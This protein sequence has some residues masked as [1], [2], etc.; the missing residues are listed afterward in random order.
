VEEEE[1]D[2]DEIVKKKQRHRRVEEEES[3]EG[4][5]EG[6]SSEGEEEE[7]EEEEEGDFSLYRQ[8]ENWNDEINEDTPI[9]R[10]VTHLLFSA[11]LSLAL[12]LCLTLSQNMSIPEAMTLFIEMIAMILTHNTSSTTHAYQLSHSSTPPRHTTT[13]SRTKSSPSKSRQPLSSLVT[14]QQKTAMRKIEGL[15]CTSRESLLGSSAWKGEFYEQLKS[16]P[17]YTVIEVTVTDYHPSSTPS[18]SV[19]IVVCLSVCLFL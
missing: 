13:T 10:Q 19:S 3:E 4:D 8:L 14:S 11:P 7:D 9:F 5:E 12:P 15:I 2:D 16:R 17:F 6:D 18:L 1:D